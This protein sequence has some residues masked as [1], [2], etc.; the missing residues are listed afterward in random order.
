MGVMIKMDVTFNEI[1]IKCNSVNVAL[2]NRIIN[3]IKE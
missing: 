2:L 1:Q 3:K